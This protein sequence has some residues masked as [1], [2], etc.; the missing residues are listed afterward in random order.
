LEKSGKGKKKHGHGGT[1]SSYH[2]N[3]HGL[4]IKGGGGV[5]V[6]FVRE[7]GLQLI[8]FPCIKILEKR[9]MAG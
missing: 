7:G 3:I 6:G 4:R 5:T 8:L 2:W 9:K 1:L